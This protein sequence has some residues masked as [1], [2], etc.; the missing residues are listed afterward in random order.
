MKNNNLKDTVKNVNSG[1]LT[2]EEI[3]ENCSM[4]QSEITTKFSRMTTFFLNPDII[5]K[6]IKFSLNYSNSIDS[7]KWKKYSHNSTEILAGVKNCQLLEKLVIEQE[8]DEEESEEEEEEESLNESEIDEF[9]DFNDIDAKLMDTSL[10]KISRKNSVASKRSEKKLVKEQNKKINY[11]YLDEI[12][13]FIQNKKNEVDNLVQLVDKRKFSKDSS[14]KFRSSLV[15]SIIL[16]N[17]IGLESKQEKTKYNL[18]EN[19]INKDIINKEIT[20]KENTNNDNKLKASPK[21]DNKFVRTC[22]YK[23]ESNT[24]KVEGHQSENS[25]EQDE[26][27]VDPEANDKSLSKNG[28][29][30]NVGSDKSVAST[31]KSITEFNQQE[32]LNKIHDVLNDLLCGYFYRIFFN[33]VTN[34]KKE[35]N[36]YLFETNI[37]H[38]KNMIYLSIFQ[39]HFQNCLY[40]LFSIQNDK[41]N[42]AKQKILIEI[43]IENFQIINPKIRSL[44]ESNFVFLFEKLLSERNLYLRYFAYSEEENLSIFLE[45]LHKK[46]KRE[47]DFLKNSCN[48]DIDEENCFLPLNQKK[49][50]YKTSNVFKAECSDNELGESQKHFTQNITKIQNNIKKDNFFPEF[51]IDDLLTEKEKARYSFRELLLILSKLLQNMII[52]IGL[53][54]GESNDEFVNSIVTTTQEKSILI[55]KDKISSL[56]EVEKC[57]KKIENVLEIPAPYIKPR[58]FVLKQEDPEVELDE[59]EEEENE[60]EPKSKKFLYKNKPISYT[61]SNSYSIIKEIFKLLIIDLSNQN[62]Q[63]I[64]GLENNLKLEVIILII[65]LFSDINYTATVSEKI[66]LSKS[67]NLNL[68]NINNKSRSK[69][70][71]KTTLNNDKRILQHVTGGNF[72]IKRHDSLLDDNTIL[73]K[74]FEI[75]VYSFLKF[76]NNNILH[77]NFEFLIQFILSD[78]CPNEIIDFFLSEFNIFN[79]INTISK[80]F[81]CPNNLVNICEISAKIFLSTNIQVKNC[82]VKSKFFK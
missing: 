38:L 15:E 11:P 17:N 57:D 51:H 76:E 66:L 41:E 73:K 39:T 69:L 33:L 75:L 3:L 53:S 81:K 82:L 65:E 80:N 8:D 47:I 55:D 45:I 43:I 31:E 25:M 13:S 59:E 74:F 46:I 1:K 71:R 37:H 70:K 10:K 18:F 26:E 23:L 6:L 48:E 9:I 68:D 21:K 5:T 27:E 36:K 24:R 72:I 19:N 32:I 78:F 34:K 42:I 30:L 64:F 49:K 22:T 28:I 61:S 77:K 63:V 29:K 7:E 56:N 44:R 20:N 4:I 58:E 14:L 79:S 35:M 50:S 12:F 54:D 2:I 16:E 60:P 67:D 62:F 40:L 52:D